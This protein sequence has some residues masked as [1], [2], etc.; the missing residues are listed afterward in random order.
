M[1]GDVIS[2]GGAVDAEEGVEVGND[3]NNVEDDCDRDGDNSVDVTG[4]FSGT[5]DVDR[6]NGDSSS[7][8]LGGQPLCCSV[9][10]ECFPCCS[11][12]SWTIARCSFAEWARNSSATSASVVVIICFPRVAEEEEEEDAPS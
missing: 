6:V 10:C 11:M 1:E 7:A 4:C 3:D 2:S 12:A 9:A 8:L 5:D